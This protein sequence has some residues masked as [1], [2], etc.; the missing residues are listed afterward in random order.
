M[1]ICNHPWKYDVFLSFRGEDTRKNFTDHL[2]AALDQEGLRIFRDHESIKRGTEISSE[3]LKAIEDSMIWIIIFS[4]NYA[5]ST[6]CLDE[7][8]EIVDCLDVD[9]HLAVVPA[10]YDINP[11]GVKVASLSGWHLKDRYAMFF[12]GQICNFILLS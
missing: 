6:W 2:R 3:L 11:S 7:L 10:F 5:S 9:K 4:R 1:A 8:V 12:E